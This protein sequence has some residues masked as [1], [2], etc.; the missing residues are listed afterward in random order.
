MTHL[1]YIHPHTLTCMDGQH[2]SRLKY[3]FIF[4]IWR[5]DQVLRYHKVW[6]HRGFLRDHK[7]WG[8]RGF[9]RDHKVWDH[10][11]FLRD[12]KVWGHR[13][14]LIHLVRGLGFRG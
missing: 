6:G 10:R 13:G 3:G 5:D 8:H 11:G 9:L 2:S 12:H 7:V 4:R 14:V 1:Q